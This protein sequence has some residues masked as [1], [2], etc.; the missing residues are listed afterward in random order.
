MFAWSLP[1]AWFL[2]CTSHRQSKAGPKGKKKARNMDPKLKMLMVLFGAIIGLSQLNDKTLDRMR[3]QLATR[4]W[5]NIVPGW[6]KS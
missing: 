2:Q 3:R 1:L 4:R 5:R 6:R